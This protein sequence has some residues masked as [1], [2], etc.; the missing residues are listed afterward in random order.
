MNSGVTAGGYGHNP[1]KLSLQ[2]IFASNV[3]INNG[4]TAQANVHH[5]AT[6]GDW[7]IANS[8]KSTAEVDSY[9]GYGQHNSSIVVI[10]DPS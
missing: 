6:L 5:G 1:T 8:F 9:E 10:F 3:F 2:N 4:Q 7:W